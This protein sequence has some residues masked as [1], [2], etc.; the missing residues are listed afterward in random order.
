[1]SAQVHGRSAELDYPLVLSGTAGVNPVFILLASACWPPGA[2][3]V[4]TA[5]TAGCSRRSACSGAPA[6][7]SNPTPASHPPRP[8]DAHVRRRVPA[9]SVTASAATGVFGSGA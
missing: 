8:P 3:P 1:M 7:C 4:G 2:T 9:W 6:R 5:S